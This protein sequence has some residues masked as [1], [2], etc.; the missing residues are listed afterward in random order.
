MI[1]FHMTPADTLTE[2]LSHAY[3]YMWSEEIFLGVK[4]FL[5]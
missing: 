1:H 3:N 5:L 2:Y 4:K